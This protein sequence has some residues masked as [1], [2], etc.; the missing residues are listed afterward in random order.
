MANDIGGVWRTIGGRRVFIKDGQSLGEAMKKSGKFKKAERLKE[1]KKS[2]KEEAD[3]ASELSKRAS[4]FE[5]RQELEK[6]Y[7]E[8]KKK[9]P[10]GT[11]DDYMQERHLEKMGQ[12]A[13]EKDKKTAKLEKYTAEELRQK[14]AAQALYPDKSELKEYRNMSP[15]DAISSLADDLEI[16]EKEAAQAL[17]PDKK[18]LLEA[19]QGIA[20]EKGTVTSEIQ[21]RYKLKDSDLGLI[22]DKDVKDFER[23]I[24]EK[25]RYVKAEE[26]KQNLKSTANKKVSNKKMTDDLK[27]FHEDYNPYKGDAKQKK[28]QV[29]DYIKNLPVGTELGL[30][31][32]E[33]S[34]GWTAYGSYHHETASLDKYK[35]VA[36]NQWTKNGGRKVDDSDMTLKALYNNNPLMDVESAKALREKESIK[37]RSSYRSVVNTG[38]DGQ[39]D[40]VGKSTNRVEKTGLK[41]A[42][43]KY[44]KEHPNSEMTLAEFEKQYG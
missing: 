42:Y 7:K 44:M 10:D 26:A 5:E 32:M 11:L 9:N 25:A 15:E 41:N 40:R 12:K 23:G 35:K 21:D 24:Q 8:Y 20:K 22:S 43:Q 17:Y 37:D 28:Q 14:E 36:E 13:K 29:E 38:R 1:I 19:I 31:T 30:V 34:S 6:G 27:K 33:S 2:V 39:G 16:S 3:I 4:S 18:E